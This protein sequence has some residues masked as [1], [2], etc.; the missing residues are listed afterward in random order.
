MSALLDRVLSGDFRD[1]GGTQVTGSVHIRQEL[2]NSILNE[3]VAAARGPVREVD[4][5]ILENNRIQIGA[6]IMIGP[7]SKWLRPELILDRQ[8]LWSGLPGVIAKI[9]SQH[10]G[11]VARIVQV[12]AGGSLP[13]GVHVKNGHVAIDFGLLP[14]TAAYGRYFRV[15]KR[16]NLTTT[17]GIFVL[18]FDVMME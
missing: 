12:F 11:A 7:F 3:E 6:R 1:L 13:T 17:S 5:R 14:Q 2:I 18:D 8:A 9:S 15:L 16:L 10:Y 4:L